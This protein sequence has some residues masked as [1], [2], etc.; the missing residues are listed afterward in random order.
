LVS[1]QD[2][3]ENAAGKH[4]I[5]AMLCEGSC[6][7]C[8]RHLA[9]G[10]ILRNVWVWILYLRRIEIPQL[11]DVPSWYLLVARIC[12]ASVS[13]GSHRPHLG[14]RKQRLQ[15]VHMQLQVCFLRC[16]SNAL[17]SHDLYNQSKIESTMDFPMDLP[18]RYPAAWALQDKVRTVEIASIVQSC[19]NHS[20]SNSF[21]VV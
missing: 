14:G 9:P 5:D 13:F 2:S 15:T 3:A 17:K 18:F 11:P 1:S 19:I 12:Q 10:F 21:Q 4:N 16:S 20:T 8:L 6:H 7:S